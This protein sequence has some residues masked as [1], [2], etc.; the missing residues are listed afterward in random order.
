[1]LVWMATLILPLLVL[2]A[3]LLRALLLR[4]R[5]QVRRVDDERGL[6]QRRRAVRGAVGRRAALEVHGAHH[7]VLAGPRED[8]RRAPAGF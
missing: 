5:A 4:G 1:M 7:D 8:G 3:E 2:R 6:V